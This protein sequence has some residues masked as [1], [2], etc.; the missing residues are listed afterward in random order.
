TTR[1]DLLPD[2]GVQDLSDAHLNILA[3]RWIRPDIARKARLSSADSIIGAS[4]IGRTKA[5]YA[6]LVIPYFMPGRD[7]PVEYQLRLDHP[8]M[9][10]DSSGKLN[11]TEI[12]EIHYSLL[13]LLWGPHAT[14]LNI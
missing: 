1:T 9:E 7:Q 8:P 14:I 2:L 10:P 11:L 3:Q 4:L 12:Q 6:G 5:A 13:P